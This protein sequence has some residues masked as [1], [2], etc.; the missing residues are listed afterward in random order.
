MDAIKKGAV[1]L[2]KGDGLHQSC[3]RRGAALLLV[4]I[5]VAMATI[6]A[7]SFLASQGPTAVVASNIDRKA[8]ARAIA[9]SALK[10]AI[11]YVNED[12]DWRTDKTSGT[13]MT[14]ASLDGGTF[15]L[16]GI[17][18]DDGDLSDDTSEAVTLSVVATYDGV[19]HRV[20][21]V[22]TPGTDDASGK[23]YLVVN[24]ATSLIAKDTARKSLAEGWGYTVSCISDHDSQATFDAAAV[25]AAVFWVTEDSSTGTLSTKLRDTAVGVMFETRSS[26][27]EFG[28]TSGPTKSSAYGTSMTVLDISHEITASLSLGSLTLA[29]SATYLGG[30]NS[31]LASG[32]ETMLD[33]GGGEAF[34]M[35]ADTGATLT[36]GPAP[37]RRSTFLTLD[38]FDINKL[39]ATGLSLLRSTIDWAA[40]EAADPP[41]TPQLLALY[42]FE[43]VTVTP[44]LAGR[45]RLDEV[46]AG[47]AGVLQLLDHLE[48][49]SGAVI[50]AYDSAD[51][52]YGVANQQLNVLVMTNTTS[53][54]NVDLDNATI[55]GD[56]KVGDGGDPSSV[57]DLNNGATITGSQSDQAENASI[58]TY[59]EPTGFPT[60]LGD[61][62]LNSSGAVAWSTDLHYDDLTISSGTTVTVTGDI[63]VKVDG[64]FTIDNSDIVLAAGASLR[65]WVGEAVDVNNGATINND[66][67]R[68]PDLELLQYGDSIDYDLDL[69]D[70]ILVGAIHSA[71]DIRIYNGSAI[72]GS[73][74]A[75]DD[76]TIY[77]GSIHIDL[78]TA[79]PAPLASFTP[80]IARDSSPLGND[81]SAFNGPVGGVAGQHGTAYE[82]DGSNDYVEIPHDDSYLMQGGTFSV[83]F[84][85]DTT[86]GK[87]GLFSKDSTDYDTG[88]HFS[89]FLDGSLIEV[90]MQSTTSSNYVRSSSGS[91][92]AGNWYHIMFAW[93][94]EGM[95]LYLNGVEV[96]TDSYTGGTG[97]T[98]GGVGNYEPIVLGANAW[99]TGDLNSSGLEGY[100]DGTLDDLRIFNE[101]LSEAQALEI[102]NGATEP[103]PFTSEVIVA[104]TSGYEDPLDLAVQDPDEVTWSGGGLTF[105]GD[106][107]AV[108]LAEATKLYD[109]INATGEFSV[110]VLLQRASPGSTASPSRIVAYSEG[111]GDSNFIL[112]QDG[113]NY[114]ARVRDSSTGTTGALSPEFIS[115]TDLASSGDTH[116]VLSY[117]DGE[118]TVYIDGALDE[119]NTAGGT[120]NNWEDDMYLVLG[121]AYGGS[122]YWNGTL[123]RVAIYDR[124][125]DSGQAEN[126]Y[127]G[128]DPGA[129]STSNSSGKTVWD[130]QD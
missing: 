63:E 109:A 24:D 40:A 59:D 111:A 104:D 8:K 39:N 65:L 67:A 13:W 12:A 4:L 100:F 1:P 52:A 45:W 50:D 43:Q 31:T 58:P 86:S 81:G 9:E 106:T 66:T 110:A 6:L 76:I 114:E 88:G 126:V 97:T 7:L 93:G 49:D 56:V 99:K 71:D 82:F 70:G 103:T 117:K 16:T 11:D 23:L 10:M 127:N 35:A 37:A 20:S 72:Y 91:I 87:R 33:D 57:I 62:T 18:T 38:T 28:F 108:S 119:T 112:G 128:S 22:V 90:R 36:F 68:A 85:A 122:S 61:V 53:S 51:G 94:E 69:N 44:T 74:V 121:G 129:P 41:G 75:E 98:S 78:S 34:V 116:I 21:A 118:V 95:V 60:T 73:V 80:T 113:T 123:K 120:L 125:F 77:D 54:N 3:R 32:V 89:V 105:D 107:L 30:T 46:G 124:G 14:D 15:T 29:T 42:E 101:R 96:D 17:D 115:S 102:Y 26:I 130:E 47:A 25:D 27:D 64:H 92:V 48:L 83:W 5:A 2:N 84:K 55:Y 19:T 79:P